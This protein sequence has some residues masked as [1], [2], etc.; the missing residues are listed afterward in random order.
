MYPSYCSPCLGHDTIYNGI[1][2]F[3]SDVF[4]KIKVNNGSFCSP[5]LIY[6]LQTKFHSSKSVSSNPGELYCIV[7][8]AGINKPIVELLSITDN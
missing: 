1:P 7:T 6:S 3:L 4:L 5:A 8:S 2:W